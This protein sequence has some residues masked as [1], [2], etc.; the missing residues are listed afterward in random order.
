MQHL[1][2]NPIW[3]QDRW[4]NEQYCNKNNQTFVSNWACDVDGGWA[5]AWAG[6]CPGQV[7]EWPS[8]YTDVFLEDDGYF[9]NNSRTY[10]SRRKFKGGFANFFNKEHKISGVSYDCLVTQ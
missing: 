9:Y 2:H 8:N 3:V 1:Q 10:T 5:F 7:I 6:T 4:G